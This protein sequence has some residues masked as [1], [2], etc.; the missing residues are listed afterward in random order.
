MT[1][2]QEGETDSENE[3]DSDDDDDN[4]HVEEASS[5]QVDSSPKSNFVAIPNE[6]DSDEEGE[7]LF[8]DDDGDEIGEKL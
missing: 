1:K 4:T 7:G 6:I 5:S 3:G 8:S 2:Q